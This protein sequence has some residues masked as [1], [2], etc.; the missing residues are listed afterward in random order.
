MLKIKNAPEPNDHHEDVLRRLHKEM[1][2]VEMPVIRTKQ[3]AQRFMKRMY[4]AGN[5][6]HVTD[7]LGYPADRDFIENSLDMF[8][9]CRLIVWKKHSRQ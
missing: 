9:D 5:T 4:L 6:V 3:Q 7:T 1:R 8:D 2:K